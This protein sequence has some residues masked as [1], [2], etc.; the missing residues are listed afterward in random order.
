L[1][2]AV[3]VVPLVQQVDVEADLTVKAL[4]S[5]VLVLTLAAAEALHTAAEAAVVEV[6]VVALV[7][8]VEYLKDGFLSLLVAQLVQVE[9][10][11]QQVEL[12]LL[13]A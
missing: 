2:V 8:E 12:L 10:Q 3:L 9:E 6:L 7:V 4:A 5:L 13:V 11:A 1:L